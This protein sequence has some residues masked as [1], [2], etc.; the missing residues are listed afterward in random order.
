MVA[1]CGGQRGVVIGRFWVGVEIFNVLWL[2]VSDMGTWLR[3][4]IIWSSFL[5][6][7]RVLDVK[8]D[9]AED[10]TQRGLRVFHCEEGWVFLSST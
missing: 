10:I 3:G 5:V 1:A 7:S 6:S 2:R 4:R 9:E 8:R